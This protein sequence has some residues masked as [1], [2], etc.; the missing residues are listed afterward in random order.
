MSA[1]QD[2]AHPARP[3]APSNWVVKWAHLVPAG[4]RVLDLACG[5]GRHARYFAARGHPVVACDRDSIALAA[6]KGVRGI[7]P[8][9]ADLERGDPWPCEPD[10]FAGVVVTNY[11]HRPLFPALEAALSAGGVLIYETFLLGNEQYGKPSNPAFLLGRDELLAAFGRGLAVVGYE[12]GRI[13]RG[14]TALIQ[15]LCAM[16]STNLSNDLEPPGCP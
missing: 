7:E 2:A 13:H 4:G 10:S 3:D 9:L 8:V 11:L 14:K 12:Q 6:L 1:A 16:R 15:R 5:Y